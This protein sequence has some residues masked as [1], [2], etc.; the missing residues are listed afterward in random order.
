MDD[1]FAT[2]VTGSLI[3]GFDNILLMKFYTNGNLNLFNIDCFQTRL[4]FFYH[5]SAHYAQILFYDTSPQNLAN[6]AAM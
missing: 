1:L 3:I 6:R 2:K 5:F 4:F